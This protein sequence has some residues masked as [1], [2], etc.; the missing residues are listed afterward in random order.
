MFHLHSFNKRLL[1][2]YCAPGTVL[3]TMGKSVNIMDM[4]PDP[5]ELTNHAIY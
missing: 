3:S 5:M 4:V 2:G 1:N